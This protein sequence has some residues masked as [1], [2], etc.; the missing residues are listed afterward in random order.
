M[1]VEEINRKVNIIYALVG[2]L[3]NDKQVAEQFHLLCKK[4]NTKLT[5]VV[6]CIDC[7]HNDIW[8]CSKTDNYKGGRLESHKKKQFNFQGIFSSTL[9]W[10]ALANTFFAVL[11]LTGFTL[12]DGAVDALVAAVL[13]KDWGAI[14]S[15]LFTTIIPTVARFFKDR[16]QST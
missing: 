2:K 4:F 10:V 16:K 14:I 13:A 8:R 1:T 9:T 15:M 11:A 12:P 7:P 6:F 5:N 3:E